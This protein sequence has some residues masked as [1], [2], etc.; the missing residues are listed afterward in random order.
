MCWT[1]AAQDRYVMV[2]S[3][4]AANRTS[5]RTLASACRPCPGG[6]VDQEHPDL[7]VLL[8]ANG[9]VYWRATPAAYLLG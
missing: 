6:V 9:S 3:A 1:L 7:R 5:L 2:D 4:L 8:L